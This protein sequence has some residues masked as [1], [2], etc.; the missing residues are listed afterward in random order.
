MVRIQALTELMNSMS[1]KHWTRRD[2]IR[3]G[4]TATAATTLPTW[5]LESCPGKT[6]AEKSP[7]ERPRIALIGCGGMGTG[8]AAN[9][10]RFGDIVAIC[11][12]D[13]NH[14]DKLHKTYGKAQKYS[15]YREVCDLPNVDI[16][17]NATPDHWHTLVNLRAIHNGKDVYSEKPL[18]LTIDEGKHVVA[19]VKKTGAFCKP[20]ANSEAI[21]HSALRAN[22][23]VM[24]ALAKSSAFAC[25]CRQ[26]STEGRSRRS[27]YRKNSTGTSGRGKLRTSN[28]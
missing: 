6:V 11:D 10:K 25:G 13:T 18:T 21:K 15:D 4:L 9:A 16:I 28:T 27:Q 5:Y 3:F 20:A 17:I 7:N 23:F 14:L 19:A 22:L 8:D 1:N 26:A 2:A 12:V 24:V